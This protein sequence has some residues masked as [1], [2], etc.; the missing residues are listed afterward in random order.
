MLQE[1]YRDNCFYTLDLFSF[2]SRD[3]TERGIHDEKEK[4]LETD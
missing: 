3:K 4:R 2:N 1:G